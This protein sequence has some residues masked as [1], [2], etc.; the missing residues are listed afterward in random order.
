[1]K[2]SSRTASPPVRNLCK[3][4]LYSELAA[5]CFSE[6]DNIYLLLQVEL[7]SMGASS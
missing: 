4:A 5:F 3:E 2:E 1:M 7:M 6:D